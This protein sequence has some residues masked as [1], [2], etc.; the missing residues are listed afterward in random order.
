MGTLYIFGAS[1]Q[2]SEEGNLAWWQRRGLWSQRALA[3]HAVSAASITR[4]LVTSG[5]S[6]GVWCVQNLSILAFGGSPIRSSYYGKIVPFLPFQL[7]HFAVLVSFIQKCQVAQSSPICVICLLDVERADWEETK[8]VEETHSTQ[9]AG[10]FLARLFLY[11]R[12]GR[13]FD[14]RK[15]CCFEEGALIWLNLKLNLFW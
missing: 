8:A 14:H 15:L 7:P 6:D 3:F 13:H 9:W 12:D 2:A 11:H 1:A 4:F 5:V 10:V